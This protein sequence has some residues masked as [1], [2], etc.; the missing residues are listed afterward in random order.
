MAR[1]DLKHIRLLQRSLYA[2]II[3]RSQNILNLK[4]QKSWR[5]SFKVLP[6]IVDRVKFEIAKF[7]DGCDDDDQGNSQDGGSFSEGM[8]SKRMGFLVRAQLHTLH[9]ILVDTVKFTMDGWGGFFNLDEEFA[10]RG[11]SSEVQPK[12]A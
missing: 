11:V 12:D 6:N 9:T 10:P 3:A 5:I 8:N 1:S 2:F 4:A 7:D